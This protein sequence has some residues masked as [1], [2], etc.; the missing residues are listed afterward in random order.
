MAN[1]NMKELLVVQICLDRKIYDKHMINIYDKQK[2][3]HVLLKNKI[4]LFSI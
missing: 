3:S 4:N 1:C 2:S